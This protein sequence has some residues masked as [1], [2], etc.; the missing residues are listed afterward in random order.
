MRLKKGIII[1]DMIVLLMLFLVNFF[2]I[3]SCA[4]TGT[5]IYV[6]DSNTAG[7]WEGT[8]DFPYKTIHEGIDAASAN[9]TVY[10]FS[11]TY[12]ENVII[13]KDLVLVGENKDT[14]FIDGGGNGHVL[15]AHDPTDN[16]IIVSIS[17]FTIRNPGAGGFDCVTFSYVINGEI[18]DTKI[19]N[20]QEGEGIFLDH[21]N[22][23]AIHDNII[24]SYTV[25][26]TGI[27]LA[28]SDQ[29]I[30]ENNIIQNNQKGI[31]LGSSSTNN[32]IISNTIRDNSAYGIYIVQ[33]SISNV[34]SL[35]DFNGDGY[36][37]NGQNAKDS[38]INLWSLDGQGNYWM[39]Y[40]KYDNNSDGI[41]D[42]PYPIPGGNNVDDYP[43]GYFKQPEQ[44]G[45]NQPPVAVSLSISKTSANSG[46]LISFTGEGTDTDGFIVGYHWRSNLDGTLSTD[47]SFSTSTLSIGTHTIYFK[48]QDNNGAW[49]AEKIASLTINSLINYLPTAYIDE[50]S[51]NPAKQGEAVVFKGHGS[52]QDGTIIGYK[53]LSSKDGII[54][55][56]PSFS[57]NNLSLG[58]HI[59]YFQVK[60]NA[61]D[62]SPSVSLS[63]IIEKNFSYGGSTNH[64][65]VVDIGGPY[66][67][68]VNT[69]VYFDGSGSFDEDGEI[70]SYI[71]DYGDNH[72]GIGVSCSHTYTTPGIYTVTLKVIDDVGGN[73]T[74]FT[75][76]EIRQSTSQGDFQGL[77][78]G[79]N[80]DIPFPVLIVI[81]ILIILGI[82]GGFFFRLRRR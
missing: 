39:D 1:F 31:Q 29:D 71:W 4:A 41:G 38:F 30:I 36:S 61:N 78:P 24:S 25:T 3:E 76:V 18:A 8:L 62:M 40:N 21:C 75:A 33:N 68:I 81:L 15:N 51:P 57:K 13:T 73:A 82:I 80:F 59:I 55:T 12:N 9:D 10:V 43:L 54:S 37:G 17:N 69:A 35:N 67:G 60:D 46:E 23:V 7:P 45:G 6:D 48:V 58:N 27:S 64:F 2:L 56:A 70:I 14:T 5:T 52:D 44:P 49:S 26:G 34:F 66:Q 72:S 79:L 20:S 16:E 47:Q 28:E 65:P 63:L 50:I 11:G 42:T 32:H 74:S 77:F 19:L 53:W 22:E